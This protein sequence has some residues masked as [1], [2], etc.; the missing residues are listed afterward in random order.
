MPFT[1][2]VCLYSE[3]AKIDAELVHGVKRSDV[4]ARYGLSQYRL[5]RH[6]E[7]CILPVSKTY[8][9]I[10]EVATELGE[11]QHV[12]RYW[13]TSFEIKLSRPN[14]KDRRYRKEDISLLRD[15]QKLIRIDGYSHRGVKQILS[16]KTQ[17]ARFLKVA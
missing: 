3:R 12:L 4:A 15:I 16:D 11:P 5:A 17:Y 7:K 2:A 6:F 14:S 9:R 8:W 10:S 13:E 1:C